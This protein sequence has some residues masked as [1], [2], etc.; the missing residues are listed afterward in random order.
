MYPEEPHVD[1]GEQLLQNEG[2]EGDGVHWSVIHDGSSVTVHFEGYCEH[3]SYLLTPG[4]MRPA[5]S[6]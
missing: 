1:I 4:D 5:D 2:L 3:V 6:K